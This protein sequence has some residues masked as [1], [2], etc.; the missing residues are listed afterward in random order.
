[1]KIFV[2]ARGYPSKKDP[3]W[4]C[5]EKDQAEALSK[6]GHQIVIL[7]VDTRFRFYWRPIGIQHTEH[8]TMAAYNIF[9]LPYALLF[10]VPKRIKNM[11]YAWQLELLYKRAVQ[12]Y[13]EPD[14][15]YSHYLHNTNKAL[16]I[17]EKY[18]IP[19]V[20]VEHWSRMAFQPIPKNAMSLARATYV[21]IDQLLTVSSALQSN[22]L[23]QIGVSSIVV[24]NMVGNEFFYKKRTNN[25]TLHLIATG[26][27]VFEKRFD[28]LIS[29][30]AHLTFP[31]ELSI[32]GDG[33]EKKNLQQIIQRYGLE[34]NI[35]LLGYKPK[36]ELAQILQA[37]DIFVLPSQSETFGVAY[38]EAL[39]CGLPVIATDCGGPRD[40][41]NEDN[42]II[43]PIDDLNALQNAIMHMMTNYYHYNRQQ[44]AE[45]CQALFS[46][47]NIAMQIT[48]ILEDTYKKAKAII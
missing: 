28:L 33:P 42:G 25:H 17:H 6:L 23:Q 48:Q 45:N 26:R 39:A 31:Y 24:P 46:S 35:H 1:M 16:R 21:Y 5:F 18:N 2:I 43:I 15:L 10:F 40:F 37:S 36:H 41:V 20:G 19:V 38:I 44:I 8:N 32:I 30:L 27:L 7:S 22:I 34:K 4:G 47:K 12:T 9:L 3:T 14:I 29:A 13:G 11:F